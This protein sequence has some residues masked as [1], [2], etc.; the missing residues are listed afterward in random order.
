NLTPLEG[1]P[2]TELFC[3][4]TKVS[5]LTPLRDIMSLKKLLISGTDVTDLTPLARI[6]LE[7]LGLTPRP[8]KGIE[9][10][11]AM[12]TIVTINNKRAA[13]FWLEYDPK[14]PPK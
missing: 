4:S 5:S 2:L 14:F 8:Y 13:E 9:I 11:R 1:M 3:M 12:K 10:I 7:E 6:P